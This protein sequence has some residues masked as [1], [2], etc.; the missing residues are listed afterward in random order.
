MCFGQAFRVETGA[1]HFHF[2]LAVC[3]LDAAPASNGC[4]LREID[5]DVW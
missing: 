1:G 4:D 5:L 2:D 3:L